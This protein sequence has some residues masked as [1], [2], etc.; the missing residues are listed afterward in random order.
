V[1]AD[2]RTGDTPTGFEA[3]DTLRL[4]VEG[5]TDGI[6]YAPIAGVADIS[7]TDATLDALDSGPGIETYQTQTFNVPAFNGSIRF[8]MQFT[9]TSLSA[10][11]FIF[12]DNVNITLN[13]TGG[14]NDP[15]QVTTNPNPP[16]PVA[17]GGTIQVS[18]AAAGGNPRDAATLA[19]L[20]I[21]QGANGTFSQAGL[22]NGS[23]A[24]GASQT[25][26]ISFNGAGLL[27]GTQATASL[28]FDIQSG[29]SGAGTGAGNKTYNLTATVSGNQG[30]QASSVAAGAGYA[31]LSGNSNQTLDTTASMLGGTNNGAAT[32]LSMVW[33][34]RA[35][36]ET[37]PNG[38]SPP[39]PTFASGL[40]SDVLNL[41]G[42]DGDTFVLQMT[43]DPTQL[44]GVESQVIG[45]GAL[46]LVSRG[47]TDSGNWVNAVDLNIGQ[48][49][50]ATN[51]QGPWNGSLA[52][53][54][55]GVDAANN[56][57]WA[58]VNHDGFFAVVPEPGS[59]VL[60]GMG[61]VGLMWAV[62][63]RK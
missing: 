49:V 62:R 33:R 22:A 54:T 24:A 5:T 40:L 32:T 41:D 20:A 47:Q 60:A 6:V 45:D 2:L 55:W 25:G 26:T 51:V 8:G 15:I 50:G 13:P 4:F 63:R 52:L 27:N 23:I 57:V 59:F 46:F 10:N 34:A 11:E 31:G 12:L 44:T 9:S 16:G 17:A 48:N 35:A 42:A 61:L 39:L 43:Y 37:T 56:T 3:T 19:N 58:V 14:L 30:N 36:N 18:N 53:G 21:T 38:T 7:F 29:P 1:T 28:S